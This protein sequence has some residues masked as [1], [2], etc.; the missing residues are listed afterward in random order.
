[1]EAGPGGEKYGKLSIHSCALGTAASGLAG[2]SEG[3]GK[4]PF[5]GDSKAKGKNTKTNLRSGV[6]LRAKPLNVVSGPNRV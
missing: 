5:Q 1:M 3:S 4:R 2:M 6:H